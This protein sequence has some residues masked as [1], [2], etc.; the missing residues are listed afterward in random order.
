MGASSLE[1]AVSAML[2]RARSPEW[3]AQQERLFRDAI[4]PIQAM[5]VHLYSLYLPT[6]IM[7]SKGELL[8]HASNV[9]RAGGW[10]NAR[11]DLRRGVGRDQTQL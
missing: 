4:E 8:P 10:R 6:L 3:C 9:R 7:D 2:A 11:A 5:K 1:T